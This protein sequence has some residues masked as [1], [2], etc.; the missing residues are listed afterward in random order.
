VHELASQERV[1]GARLVS[2]LINNYNYWR[3]LGDAIESA[4]DQ[5]YRLMRRP[6]HR[7]STD[8]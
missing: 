2:I 3:F 7:G 8:R 5:T 6:V 1:T 4:L